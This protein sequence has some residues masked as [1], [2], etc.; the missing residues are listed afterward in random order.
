MSRSTPRFRFMNRV[1]NPIVRT[2]LRSPLHRL[3]SGRL[4]L[5]EVRGKKSGRPFEFPVGYEKTAD[6]IAITV[7]W[8]ERKRW[9]R[10]IGPGPTPV[11]IRMAGRDR[12]GSAQLDR[13]ENGVVR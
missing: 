6:G 12:I 9:W 5:I 2:L 3:A 10:N 1:V 11:R 13:S 7:G 8:P 4:V